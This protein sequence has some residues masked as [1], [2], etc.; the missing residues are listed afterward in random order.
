MPSTPLSNYL[1]TYRRRGGLS[2]GE[3]GFLLGWTTGDNVSRHE[4][5]RRMPNFEHLLGYE[6][7][8]RVPIRELFAGEF[9]RIE[10]QVRRRAERLASRIGRQKPSPD[11]E[12]KL[13]A[14]RFLVS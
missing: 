2:Q 7:I 12:R 6:V 4:F 3:I 8:L 5:R 11:R 9:E 14:L 1:R 10:R 13:R